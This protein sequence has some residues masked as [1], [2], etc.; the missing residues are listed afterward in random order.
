MA[1]VAFPLFLAFLA[2]DLPRGIRLWQIV[3]F[4]VILV[5]TRQ[6]FR[7]LYPVRMA[8]A[9]RKWPTTH[10]TVIGPG[11]IVIRKS[12]AFP[13]P[14]PIRRL[15]GVQIPYEYS[16]AGRAYRTGCVLP[17]EIATREQASELLE[18][19]PSG[20]KVVVR[21]NP[22]KL[23]EAVLEPVLLWGELTNSLFFVS[24][25]LFFFLLYWVSDMLSI[26]FLMSWW[27]VAAFV[28]SAVAC[29]HDGKVSFWARARPPEREGAEQASV[30][31]TGQEHYLGVS[32]ALLIFTGP[33]SLVLYMVMYLPSLAPVDLVGTAPFPSYIFVFAGGFLLTGLAIFALRH[34]LLSWRRKY[35]FFI[36]RLG[37]LAVAALVLASLA[38][39]WSGAIMAGNA[40]FDTGP[41]ETRTGTVIAIWREPGHNLDLRLEDKTGRVRVTVSVRVSPAEYE[42]ATKGT[43]VHLQIRPGFF[44]LPWI[45]SY[46][47]GEAP[48]PEAQDPQARRRGP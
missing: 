13:A 35:L 6:L 47:L 42:K 40:L 31:L 2:P 37:T 11:D 33:I 46:E 38:A 27:V 48:P 32:F 29:W 4:L 17:G 36:G 21:Y 25:Y 41:A 7:L 43:E 12:W 19:Y 15:A 1:I 9:S 3:L 18:K 28:W 30:L 10:G 44:G 24:L 34:Q 5:L 20:K 26:L 45:A 16:V 23:Q 14:I 8:L 22:R 39:L